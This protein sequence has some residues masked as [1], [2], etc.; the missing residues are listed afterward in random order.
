MLLGRSGLPTWS[1]DGKKIAFVHVEFPTLNR[2]VYIMDSDGSNPT[3]L[4]NDPAFDFDPDW[5]LK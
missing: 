2:E 5:S 3:N 4:T 1:P